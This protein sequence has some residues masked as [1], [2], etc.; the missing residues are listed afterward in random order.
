[1]TAIL[2]EARCPGCGQRVNL[3][4]EPR[5]GQAISCRGCR[6]DFEVINLDPPKLDW[7]YDGVED[8]WVMTDWGFAGTYPLPRG[9]WWGY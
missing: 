4:A 1:M 8:N 6:Q 7:G 5:L 3:G 2:V 9:F